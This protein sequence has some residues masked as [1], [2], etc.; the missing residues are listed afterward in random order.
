VTFAEDGQKVLDTVNS[1]G[2]NSFDL[3]LMDLQMPVMDGYE[4]TRR[5]R[6]IAPELPVIGLT[7]PCARGGA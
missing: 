5:L 1:L 6:V 7:A 4:A 3:V 2:V